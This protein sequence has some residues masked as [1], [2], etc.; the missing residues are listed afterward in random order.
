LA[1]DEHRHR[2]AQQFVAK[3]GKAIAYCRVHPEWPI[4]FPPPEVTGELAI[5]P[6]TYAGFEAVKADLYSVVR[7]HGSYLERVATLQ[8]HSR[9]DPQ[10]RV[11]GPSAPQPIAQSKPA[12]LSKPVDQPE[13][14]ALPKPT[15]QPKPV[16]LSRESRQTNKQTLQARVLDPRPEQRHG[17]KAPWERFIFKIPLSDCTEYPEDLRDPAKRNDMHLRPWNYLRLYQDEDPGLCYGIFMA[18]RR[19]R[20]PYADRPGECRNQHQLDQ[21][22]L[23]WIVSNRGVTHRDAEQLVE[24]YRRNTPTELQKSLK[25]P[26]VKSHVAATPESL[27]H[28]RK[29]SQTEKPTKQTFQTNKGKSSAWAN[30]MASILAK[31]EEKRKLQKAAT[32]TPIIHE[33]QTTNG[34]KQITVHPA[35]PVT[36][37]SPSS[38]VSTTD[39]AQSASPVST[40]STGSVPTQS[41]D[42]LVPVEPAPE[43]SA[44]VSSSKRASRKWSDESESE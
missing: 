33:T 26:H 16:D 9:P 1:T 37:P 36:S 12:A 2:D 43:K 8:H 24:K 20:C 40:Q 42:P 4:E 10:A 32:H 29:S 7:A 41:S 17:G 14:A 11:S 23:D 39:P 3:L 21:T 6:D 15:A 38:P 13:P 18:D 31:D 44:S 22:I 28:A 19:H 30:S 27:E 25:V 5:W 35:T 34:T